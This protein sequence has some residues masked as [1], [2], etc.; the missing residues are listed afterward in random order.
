M[1]YNGFYFWMFRGSVKK[2]LMEKY[3][4]TYAA[5]VMRKSRAV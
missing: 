3:G 1:K 5:E 4:K 2:V